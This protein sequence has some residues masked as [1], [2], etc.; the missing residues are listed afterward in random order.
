MK[1]NETKL[2]QNQHEIIYGRWLFT[3]YISI[4][5]L[6]IKQPSSISNILCKE[7]A[8]AI[9]AIAIA[10]TILYWWVLF[11]L[12]SLYVLATCIQMIL[13]YNFSLTRTYSFHCTPSHSTFSPLLISPPHLHILYTM[14]LLLLLLLSWSYVI[15]FCVVFYFDIFLH[16]NVFSCIFTF[17]FSSSNQTLPLHH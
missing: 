16:S 11:M 4:T 5:S 1:R 17:P 7:P 3:L 8:I 15:T 14:L 6:N 10:T 9:I 12:L 2:N 13:S